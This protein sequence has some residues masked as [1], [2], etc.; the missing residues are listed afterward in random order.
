MQSFR[1]PRLDPRPI[2]GEY[3]EAFW[4]QML[5]CP[6]FSSV[7][8]LS[9]LH[10]LSPGLDD[11]EDMPFLRRSR[12]SRGRQVAEFLNKRQQ[13]DEESHQGVFTLNLRQ[14]DD[15]QEPIDQVQQLRHQGKYPGRVPDA[16]VI[17]VLQLPW[18]HG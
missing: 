13:V 2:P 8:F 12:S 5:C 11:R 3:R 9:V 17:V 10:F 4:G 7:R 18:K 16:P 6:N 1:W 15:V 14:H